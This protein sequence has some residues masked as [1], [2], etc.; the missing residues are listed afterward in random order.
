MLIINMSQVVQVKRDF[1]KQEKT[2]E[3]QLGNELLSFC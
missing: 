1:L 2:F 3:E